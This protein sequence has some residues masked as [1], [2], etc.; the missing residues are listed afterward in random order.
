MSLNKTY[1]NPL[2]IS[3]IGRGM[4]SRNDATIKQ[5]REIADP[6]VL[7]DN[8]NWYMVASCGNIYE[9]ADL[10]NWTPHKVFC[11]A[12]DYYAPCICKY[13]G[14]YYIT[15]CGG[16]LFVADSPLGEYRSLGKFHFSEELLQ[17][18]QGGQP[19]NYL[20]PD[21]FSD[22]DRGLYLYWGLGKQ[23][24]GAKLCDN[25]LSALETLPKILIEFN[26]QNIWERCGSYN[27]DVRMS[28][29]EGASMYFHNGVYYLLYSSAGTQFPTYAMGAYISNTPLGDFKPQKKNPILRG[30][31][32]YVKGAGHGCIVDGPNNSVW[33]FYTSVLGGYHRYER[34]I[35]MDRVYFNKAGEIYSEGP[36][37]TPQNVP[38]SKEKNPPNFLPLSPYCET[39][40]SS[41]KEGREGLYAVDENTRSWWQPDDQDIQPYITVDLGAKF[42]VNSV[43]IVWREV[44]LDYDK[45]ITPE[46]VN[47]IIEGELDDKKEVLCDCSKNVC[48][49][50][51]DYKEFAP[52]ACRYVTIRFQQ[53]QEYKLGVIDFTVFGSSC[54]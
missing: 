7:Y 12:L 47:Y 1:C 26:S 42:L 30:V 38:L 40:D 35:G 16:E 28:W 36:T 17:E 29:T 44:G 54:L 39:I 2:A 11:S 45:G 10:I 50:C 22:G 20:D 34:R 14:K 24:Y 23:I 41:S 9:S 15:S 52:K 43:R 25:D 21:L 51:C 18:F 4:A 37:G 33:A 6:D 5:F 49:Q 31:D 48:E 27:Q 13:Q 53:K 46:P 8:G 32:G 19:I 3:N